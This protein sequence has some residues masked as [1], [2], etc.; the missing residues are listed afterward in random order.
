MLINN[1]HDP[2]VA[3]ELRAGSMGRAAPGWSVAVLEQNSDVPAP[4]GTRGR[5]AV[6]IASSPFAW[7]N[8]YAG[9]EVRTAEKFSQDGRWYLTG[10]L[11]H[12][13]A[14]G[15]C[16]FAS[17]EDDLIIMAGYRISP[18]EVEAVLLAH[19]AVADCAVYAIPDE[20]RGEALQTSVV[21]H[22]G[23][24][25]TPALAKDLQDWVKSRYAAHAY[26]RMVHFIDALPRTPS[27]KVQR[28]VLKQIAMASSR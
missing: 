4:V 17:R 16:F 22:S 5:V 8:G 21:L 11:A 9:D 28:F 15:Y 24:N 7:F 27:G 3:S 13:D 19:P 10:D 20:I 2:A 6:Q 18:Q 14:D 1:H 25:A 23:F 12:M 26:P